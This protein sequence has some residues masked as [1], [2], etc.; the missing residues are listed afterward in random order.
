MCPDR[1]PAR[2]L[3]VHLAR[4]G[5]ARGFTLIELMLVVAVIGV[6]AA[7]VYPSYQDSVRKA[8][9][10]EA[11]AALASVAQL[12]ER[13]YT[14]SNT[15]ATATIVAGA[16]GTI[17]YDNKTEN[18]YYDIQF[19]GALNATQFTIQATPHAG[20]TQANDTCTSFTL[21]QTGARGATPSVAECW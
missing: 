3:N 12:M 6:L 5:S 17:P 20:T 19:T 2:R 7:I 14:E 18:Q 16:T 15:Y 13:Y 10:T 11:R 4:P 1:S 21:D 8:R 9:R